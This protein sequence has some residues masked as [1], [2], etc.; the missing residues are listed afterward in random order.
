MKEEEIRMMQAQLV[1]NKSTARRLKVGCVIINSFD[2]FITDGYNHMPEGFGDNCEDETDSGLVTKKEL[3]HAEQDV[4][5]KAAKFGYSLNNGVLFVTHSP[6]IDCA[7]L[8]AQS[9]IKKVY[10]KYEYRLTDGID[11]LKKANIKVIKID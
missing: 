5:T 11:F 7:K 8:I 6:C 3:I 9:G 1:S 2:E 4:I 10:Y